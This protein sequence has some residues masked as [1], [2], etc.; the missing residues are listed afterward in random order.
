MTEEPK[1]NLTG[2]WHGLYTYPRELAPVYFVATLIE[3]G[4]M[5]SGSTHEAEK[6][7][8][9]SPLTLYATID[10][11]RAGRDVSFEKT[12]DGSGGWE[13][14]VA[15]DGALNQSAEEIEGRWTIA[16]SS[17]GPG[18]SGRFLMIRSSGAKE[19]VVRKAFEKV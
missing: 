7:E 1:V 16:P 2:V 18:L 12:Y 8:D 13:H 10:G 14:S 9:G 5:F 6:G 17:R 15:Y 19:A 11:S 3:S 4:R